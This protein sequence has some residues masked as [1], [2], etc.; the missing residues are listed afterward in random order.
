MTLLI[1]GK[2]KGRVPLHLSS[3]TGD[4]NGTHHC[5]EKESHAEKLVAEL[6]AP[7]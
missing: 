6:H 1:A 4:S 2:I 3:S 5:G 7:I